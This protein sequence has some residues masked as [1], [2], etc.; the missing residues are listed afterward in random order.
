MRKDFI[1]ILLVILI[2]LSGCISDSI[3]PNDELEMED[4]VDPDDEREMDHEFGKDNY[5]EVNS[6]PMYDDFFD[7]S[8][9]IEIKINI[10][11]KEIA[12][13]EQDYQKYGSEGN[14]Y[15]LADS[16]EIIVTYPN[17]E[18]VSYIIEEV[19]IRMK[20]NT[21]RNSFY[22]NGIRN[23]IHYKLSF[24]ETFDDEKLYNKTE[25]KTWEVQED[26]ENRKN[27]TFFDLRGL[28][29]KYNSEVDLTYSKDVYASRIYREYGVL[30]QQ[31]TVGI[32]NMN[33]DNNPK[34]SGTLGVYRVYEPL[35]RQFIKRNFPKDNNDGELYKATYG[36]AA[37]MP[38][39]NVNSSLSYGVDDSLPGQQKSICY[40][41]KTN[42]KTSNHENIKNLLN[43]INGSDKNLSDDLYKYIDEDSFITW[44]AIMYLS[45]DWDNFMYDSNNFFMY[46]D[47]S[48]ICYFMTFDMDRTFGLLSKHRSMASM[49]PLNTYN[50]QGN[51]NRSELLKKTIDVDNTTIQ[52]KYLAKIKEISTGVL[53]EG[54]FND[55]YHKIYNNYK[56]DIMPTM[57]TLIF[58]YDKDL[59]NNFYHLIQ[60]ELIT[61]NDLTYYNYTFKE[62]VKEKQKTVNQI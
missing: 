28:E 52:Q 24:Q 44:L 50:L 25:I 12:K 15:R 59:D 51:R 2:S 8:N 6:S 47:E 18:Q 45:G 62:Y 26:R 40:D 22:D 11:K 7:L 33:I 43:W 41:L 34:Y 9:K 46:F 55:I 5:D 53:N 29:I 17:S 49:T 42:K 3:V 13:I 32:I 21:S 31:T 56:D 23:F 60:D 38:T 4:S 27:R 57:P 10:S 58:N 35:D 20:G 19:G 14:I 30:A 39:L 37:G 1:L 16:V 54:K 61:L 48:G 36:T